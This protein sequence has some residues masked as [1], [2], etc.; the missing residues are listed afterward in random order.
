MDT[1]TELTDM[2]NTDIDDAPDDMDEYLRRKWET[3]KKHECESC[4][5]VIG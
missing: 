5:V 3:P 1:E 4:K 2:L